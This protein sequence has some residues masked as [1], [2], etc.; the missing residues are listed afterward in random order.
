M[1]VVHFR[2]L[3]HLGVN[4]SMRVV[5]SLLS[6][7]TWQSLYGIR[8]SLAQ[9]TYHLWPTQNPAY[10]AISICIKNTLKL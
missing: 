7:D 5:F 9:T 2:Q 10:I 1:I 3:F 6:L 4:P 8:Q